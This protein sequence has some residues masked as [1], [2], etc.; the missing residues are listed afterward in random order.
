MFDIVNWAAD[1][2]QLF[3]LVLLRT[4][5]IVVAAPVLSHRA[6]P[7]PAKV[8]LSL[9]L[10]FM[11]VALLSGQSIPPVM[12][13]GELAGVAVKELCVGLLIGF[14]FSL[15]LIGVQFAGELVSYQIGF[16]IANVIDPSTGN[17]TAVL[18]QFW[19]LLA[20]II[21]LT[22]NGHHLVVQALFNSYQIIPPAL[23]AFHGAAADLMITLSAFV[24]II[25]IKMAAPMLVAILLTDVALGVLSRMMPTMNVFFIGFGIK[26]AIGLLVM[27][28]ALPAFAFVL[29]KS[30]AYLD[31]QVAVLLG[32]L[33]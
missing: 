19:L 8:G 33:R 31:E 12:G 14:V 30:A 4:S 11:L 9:L 20:T 23:A 17:Q 6:I 27:A 28:A 13:L 18:G 5:G 16:T 25:A 1:K 10:S 22:I 3:M 7:A 2:T 15:I 21:F 29:E 26:V 32:A 24:F